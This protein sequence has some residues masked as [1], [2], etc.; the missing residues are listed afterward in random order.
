MQKLVYKH[1]QSKYLLERLISTNT[2]CE[3]VDIGRS[4]VSKFSQAT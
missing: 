4:K 1:Q 2:L 3:S